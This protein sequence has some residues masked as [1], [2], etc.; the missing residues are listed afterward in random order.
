MK[1]EGGPLIW[2]LWYV[3]KTIKAHELKRRRMEKGVGRW[4]E[5]MKSIQQGKGLDG[6]IQQGETV[7]D[8]FARGGTGISS[9]SGFGPSS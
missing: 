2:R 6:L 5:E 7:A 9:G 8:F 3:G 1:G 4:E